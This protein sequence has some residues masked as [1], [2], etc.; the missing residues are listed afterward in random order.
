M[1]MSD[2]EGMKRSV[3]CRCCVWLFVVAAI[4]S[5]EDPPHAP[6]PIKSFSELILVLQVVYLKGISNYKY[7]ELLAQS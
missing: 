3:R 7:V 6:P 2:E 5:T 1:N 4:D